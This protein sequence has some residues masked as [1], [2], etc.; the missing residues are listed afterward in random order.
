MAKKTYWKQEF[1]IKGVSKKCLARIKQ[2][3]QEE[4]DT[5][6]GIVLHSIPNPSCGGPG[7][8]C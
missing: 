7:D 3:I 8:P 2:L 1:V 4:A 6:G 5:E